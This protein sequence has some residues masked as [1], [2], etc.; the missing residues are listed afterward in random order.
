MIASVRQIAVL[1]TSIDG[2]TFDTTVYTPQPYRWLA[3]WV[4][5]DKVGGGDI[6]NTNTNPNGLTWTRVM[7]LAFGDSRLTLF[8]AYTGA[9]PTTD[10]FTV[11]FSA[12]TQIGCNM[13]V[14]EWDYL[15]LS[16]ALPEDVIRSVGGTPQSTI[17]S[18]TG[19]SGAVGLPAAVAAGNVAISAFGH[20]A[21]EAS[22]PRAGWNELADQLH[23]SPPRAL[24][25]QRTALD[26]STV[27]QNA[28]ATWVGNVAWGG[29]VAELRMGAEGPVQQ[30]VATGTNSATP[31]FGAGNTPAFGDLLIM[32][33]RADVNAVNITMPADWTPVSAGAT[34]TTAAERVFYKTAGAGEATAHTVSVAGAGSTQAVMTQYHR[35][36][37]TSWVLD[38]VKDGAPASGTTLTLTA[39]NPNDD[40]NEIVVAWCVVN[41]SFGAAVTLSGGYW[42]RESGLTASLRVMAEKYLYAV[43]TSTITFSWAGGNARTPSGTLATFKS[44]GGAGPVAKSDSDAGVGSAIESLAVARS[45]TE[46][47]AG[48]DAQQSSAA[49]SSS[50]AGAGT[51]AQQPFASLSS[52]D[53]GVGSNAQLLATAL[54]SLESGAGTEAQSLQA[55]LQS[56]ESGLGTETEST[57][58]GL[59]VQGSDSGVGLDGQGLAVSLTRSD[60][61]AGTE[62]QVV[63]VALGGVDFGA[64]LESAIQSAVV[65]SVD[66]GAGVEDQSLLFGLLVAETAVGDD[67]QFLIVEVSSEDWAA[68]IEEQLLDAPIVPFRGPTGGELTSGLRLG[69]LVHNG[70]RQTSLEGSRRQGEVS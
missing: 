68:A 22:T 29:A 42:V 61:G 57:L 15:E 41:G 9:A 7:T 24:E 54:S 17:T 33:V 26:G 46:T 31:D 49:P 16:G 69:V 63:A 19:V 59:A 2:S 44:A 27:E 47:G 51:E 10:D 48:S 58:S 60:Q 12:Q 11:G 66:S 23:A 35:A 40:A 34:N 21:N 5:N 53:S 28:S 8:V 38:E 4:E 1:S 36:G 6:P 70:L 32:C 65:L 14:Y 50:E 37:I 56:L 30:A 55:L 20:I 62:Q 3:A 13:A 25:N 18:G 45:S 67:F 43:E 64:G 39:D 52:V